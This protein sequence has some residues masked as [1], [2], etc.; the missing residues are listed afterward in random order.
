[1]KI[2]NSYL[3]PLLSNISVCLV[4]WGISHLNYMLFKRVGV[5]PM[6][7]WPAAGVALIAFFLWR[8]KVFAGVALG[9]VFA[10]YLSL[11]APL[12]FAISIALMNT[13]GPYLGI[14]IIDARLGEGRIIRRI[15]DVA[16][17]FAAAFVLTPILT[18]TGGIGAKL[19]LDLMPADEFRIAWSKW[20]MAHSL[21]GLLLASP[22]FAYLLT[23]NRMGI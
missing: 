12:C 21:G 5:L 7:V 15:S 4:Y 13:L 23:R 16:V 14:R 3:K 22:F 8:E 10:N 9:T 18:A 2:R 1:M 17:I 11:G 19:L 20:F 6:P